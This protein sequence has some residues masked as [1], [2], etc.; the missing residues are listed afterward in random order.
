MRLT[1]AIKLANEWADDLARMDAPAAVI[2]DALMWG[3]SEVEGG[4]HP[5][6]VLSDVKDRINVHKKDV[7]LQ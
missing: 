1:D 6:A 2:S 5:K 4:R 3:F 7:R